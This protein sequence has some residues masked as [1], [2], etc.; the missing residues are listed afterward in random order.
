MRRILSLAVV[1]C[2]LLCSCST[3]ERTYP[4]KSNEE[5]PSLSKTVDISAENDSKS[6][7]L[8]D[9]S[10]INESTGANSG[11]TPKPTDPVA[12]IPEP[13]NTDESKEESNSVDEEPT[14]EELEELFNNAMHEINELATEDTTFIVSQI[15]NHEIEIYY[16]DEIV[17]DNFHYVRTSKQYSELENY[18]EQTF[19]GE[20]LD[21]IMSTRFRDVDDILYCRTFGGASGR[22]F[23]FLSLEKI[24]EN[25]YMGKYLAY[26]TVKEGEEESTIFEV[27]KSMPDIGYPALIIIQIYWIVR[28]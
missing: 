8:Q 11:E 18:Y 14:Y 27:K 17:I 21:W 5:I 13:S 6:S 26:H 23:K 12:E 7:D 20:A 1:I 24:Q 3:A 4:D 22:G 9:D 28:S 10:K 15:F 25:N 19:T 2:C 16:D